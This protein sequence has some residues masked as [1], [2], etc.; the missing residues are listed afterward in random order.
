MDLQPDPGSG[1][2]ASIRE[3]KRSPHHQVSLHS[4]MDLPHDLEFDCAVRYVDSLPD[5]K[6]P[7]YLVLDVRL[8]WRPWNNLEIA[9][10]GQNLLDDR[11]P[12]FQELLIPTLRT[13]V[14]QSVYGK[15]TWRY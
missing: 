6:I 12:E 7:S 14:Q 10:V 2:T 5:L 15:V 9:I 8:A 13:E 11:H 4:A 3:E 1:D